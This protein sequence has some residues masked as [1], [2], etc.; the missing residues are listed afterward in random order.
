MSGRLMSGASPEAATLGVASGS[1]PSPLAAGH[2][3]TVALSGPRL[4]SCLQVDDTVRLAS[5]RTVKASV[6]IR[7]EPDRGPGGPFMTFQVEHVEALETVRANGH[8]VVL[9]EEDLLNRL[10]P[11]ELARL[12]RAAERFYFAEV[13][14][15]QERARPFGCSE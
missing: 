12:A 6:V 1:L 3:E 2:E 11:G 15:S 4:M 5:G 14:R 7:V 9:R 10:A 8:A 13:A